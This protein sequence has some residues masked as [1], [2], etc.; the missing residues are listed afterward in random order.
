MIELFSLFSPKEIKTVYSQL[1]E[2]S[3]PENYALLKSKVQS[4]KLE[5]KQKFLVEIYLFLGQGEYTLFHHP[6]QVYQELDGQIDLLND[7]QGYYP[8]PEAPLG[9]QE[10]DIEGFE[11]F[12][13]EEE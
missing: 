7:S 5:I 4:L 10:I 9:G 11:E 2:A 1:V 8:S 12:Q 13:L 6:R 3:P